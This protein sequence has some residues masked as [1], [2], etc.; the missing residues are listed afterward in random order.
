MNEIRKKIYW[1]RCIFGKV[2]K[3]SENEWSI[4]FKFSYFNRMR[5][6]FVS[7]IYEGRVDMGIDC[8]IIY[9]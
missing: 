1:K 4:F 7:K 3:G 5:R 8:I 6:I 2:F 9:V